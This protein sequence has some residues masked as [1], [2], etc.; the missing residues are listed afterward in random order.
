MSLSACI[1]TH[2]SPSSCPPQ[3]GLRPACRANGKSPT[4][5]GG[6][7]RRSLAMPLCQRVRP[8]AG[9]KTLA[10]RHGDACVSM[11]LPSS[12]HVYAS[13]LPHFTRSAH[14]L[15]TLEVHV[16]LERHP[17]RSYRLLPCETGRGR[18]RVCPRRH[19][20]SWARSRELFITCLPGRVAIRRAISS[21]YLG[22][23]SV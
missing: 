7:V 17:R 21:E 16:N 14:H 1:D 10:G 12:E 23:C 5:M 3:E 19:S 15:R 9:S 18:K 20:A 22:A 8:S 13:A 6:I 2:Y 4:I 11:R